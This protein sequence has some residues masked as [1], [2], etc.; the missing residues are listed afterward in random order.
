MQSRVDDLQDWVRSQIPEPINKKKRV[1]TQKFNQLKKKVGQ[2][3]KKT[4][5]KEHKSFRKGYYKNYSIKGRGGVDQETFLDD[6]KP[7]LLNFFAQQKRSIKCDQILRMK[8]TRTNLT[9]GM[10]DFALKDFHSGMM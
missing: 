7:R 10:I 6:I 9:T 8:D 5:P 2:A 1:L 4:L 3:F